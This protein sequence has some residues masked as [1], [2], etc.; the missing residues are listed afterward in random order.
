M[1]NCNIV[2]DL[3][4]LVAEDIASEE[5]CNLVHDHINSCSEC[6]ETW[7]SIN[8]IG[9]TSE[10]ESE[11]IPIKKVR[12]KI[13]ADKNRSILAIGLLITYVLLSIFQFL[14]RPILLPVD[15][16]IVGY[17]E[18]DGNIILTLGKEVTGFNMTTLQTDPNSKVQSLSL[19]A[20]T[21]RIDKYMP[22]RNEANYLI[23]QTKRSTIYYV[24]ENEVD[25]IIGT[26]NTPTS[27]KTL[28]RLALNLYVR[29]AIILS[30][31]GTSLFVLTKLKYL[32]YLSTFTISYVIS[33]L[34]VVGY[35]GSSYQMVR[36]FS[37]IIILACILTIAIILLFQI[38][39]KD[40]T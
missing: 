16:A 8:D 21:N 34:L 24:S 27:Q 18:K 31:V 22:D 26:Y 4:P 17:E 25:T 1:N 19:M 15:R 14:T 7:E 39:N 33:H 28:P 12:D 23:D 38:R 6:K 5:S 40:L 13:K 2:K 11:T 29:L 9:F 37:I 20:W 30:L 10:H 3:I 36:D 32:K 35:N